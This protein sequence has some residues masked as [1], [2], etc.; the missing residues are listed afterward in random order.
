MFFGKEGL[1]TVA[2]EM[3]SEHVEVGLYKEASCFIMKAFSP[4]GC[5]IACDCFEC[6]ILY[7]LQ[8]CYIY[9]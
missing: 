1:I 2:V 4:C 6:T 9:I 8:L 3:G 5:Y 7:G